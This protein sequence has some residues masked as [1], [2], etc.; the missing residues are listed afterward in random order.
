M[1]ILLHTKYDINKKTVFKGDNYLRNAKRRALMRFL[2]FT[3][4][5]INARICSTKNYVYYC[6]RV[7]AAGIG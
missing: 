2:L 5:C 1:K 3:D 7:F 4:V 6:G